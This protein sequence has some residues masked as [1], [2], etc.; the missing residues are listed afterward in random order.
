MDTKCR[1]NPTQKR[2]QRDVDRHCERYDQVV[3]W[4]AFDAVQSCK[5]LCQ[6]SVCS[7]ASLSLARK[8]GLTNGLFNI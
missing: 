2:N 6:W 3:Q 4:Q 8:L 7:H 5:G 1:H